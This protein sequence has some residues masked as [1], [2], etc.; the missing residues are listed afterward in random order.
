MFELKRRLKFKKEN[1]VAQLVLKRVCEAW[2]VRG[3][4]V[5]FVCSDGDPRLQDLRNAAVLRSSSVPQRVTWPGCH[6]GPITL[7]VP[8]A[9]RSASW[10]VICRRINAMRRDAGSRSDAATYSDEI[11]RVSFFSLHRSSGW[12]EFRARRRFMRI[13]S[14][15]I[16]GF[17][18]SAVDPRIGQDKS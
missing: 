16:D 6:R 12:N 2:T 10:Q 4:Q 7:L 15:K 5:V 17:T 1:S 13:E 9:I 18:E 14:H 3:V 8:Y 11:L